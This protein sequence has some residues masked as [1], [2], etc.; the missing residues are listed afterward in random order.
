[1][2]VTAVDSLGRAVTRSQTYTIPP[3]ITTPALTL[4]P[5]KSINHRI[6]IRGTI[7]SE[8]A[9]RV[10]ITID[11]RS[12]RGTRRT[13]RKVTPNNGRF[14]AKI[15]LRPGTYRIRVRAPSTSA[16]RAQ[17]KIRHITVR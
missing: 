15:R 5:P 12:R 9:G 13:S 7:A 14:N 17:S 11:R 2:T 10:A 4:A 8:Y 1:V 6:H 16:H 3:A